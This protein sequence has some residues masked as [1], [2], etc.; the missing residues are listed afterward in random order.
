MKE[1]VRQFPASPFSCFLAS[2]TNGQA[3]PIASSAATYLLIALT[4]QRLA[5]LHLRPRVLARRS[6]P[7]DILLVEVANWNAFMRSNDVFIY[8]E[9]AD[10]IHLATIL[11]NDSSH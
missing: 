10:C 6:V 4:G 7:T 9:Q 1:Q 8:D 3:S 11:R 2:K 5:K